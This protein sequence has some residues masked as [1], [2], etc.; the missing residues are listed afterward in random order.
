M[1]SATRTDFFS[2]HAAQHGRPLLIAGPCSAESAEQVLATARALLPARPALFRAGVW[3]PRTRPNSFEGFGSDALRWLQ[4]V[5]QQ[6]GLKVTTEVANPQQAEEALN[7]GIDVLW[8][9]ART[10]VNPFL[11]QDIADALRGTNV[12][13]MVKNPVNPELQLWM[14]AIERLQQVGLNDI[15]AIHRGF[16]RYGTSLYRN[17]PT[18][19]IPIELKKQLP[20]LPL[21]CDPS[22]IGGRR[23]LIQRISQ[24][25]LDL[26]YD[27]LM[28]E[29]HPDPDAAM[30]DAS[31]QIT[32][33]ELGLILEELVLRAPSTE[34]PDYLLRQEEFRSR[35]DR[36]DRELVEILAERMAVVE[37]LGEFKRQNNVTILQME[38]WKEIFETRPAWAK[39][40]G[41]SA[42][43][44]SK[45]YE[46]IHLES[47]RKQ[48]EEMNRKDSL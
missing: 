20:D 12:P 24:K 9:G 47:I 33:T 22:H 7:Y 15:A 2:S 35:I 32:P 38:R 14:G 27:G 5:K 3:K 23:D 45:L 29:T 31:Q 41:V 21:F 26:N 16:S 8:I 17:P 13:V 44:V 46:Q 25:A 4:Q 37:K 40:L 10:T 39:K 28:I 6:T 11:V 42:E 48:E 18:W 36:I 43:F 19:Q 30:S 1:N 34:N